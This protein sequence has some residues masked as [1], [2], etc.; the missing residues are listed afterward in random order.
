MPAVHRGARAPVDPPGATLKRAR[1]AAGW[2]QRELAARA[3]VHQPQVARA[4]R[5]DDLQVSV[6]AR[7]AAPLGLQP[8]LLAVAPGP[9]ASAPAAA[10]AL[11]DTVADSF[12]SWR[13]TW[14]ALDPE[15]FA[16]QAR[17]LRAGRH[18]ESAIEHSAKLHGLS[19]GDVVVLG[20]LRRSGSAH[21]STPTELKKLLWISLPGLKKR[22]DK[23]EERGL[24]TRRANPRD[25]RG[26]VVALT[27][28]GLA[29][30]NGLV[31]NSP[32]P[33]WH[34]LLETAPADLRQLSGLLR[35]FLARLEARAAG[36]DQGKPE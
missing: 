24:I 19:G 10:A 12:E 15:L 3:G 32:E 35:S 36:R 34:T 30:V 33:L 11:H 18:V 17:M 23:L 7:I 1:L 22:L 29:I 2:S 27:K 21:E 13:R 16:V 26:F 25:A 6:L 31:R 14:P 8:G 20:T 9:G 5:G 4:E 28:A